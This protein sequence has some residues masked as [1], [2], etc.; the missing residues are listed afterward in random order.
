LRFKKEESEFS[1][2][3]SIFKKLNGVIWEVSLVLEKGSRFSWEKLNLREAII[4]YRD[5]RYPPENKTVG[6][7]FKNVLAEQFPKKGLKNLPNYIFFKNPKSEIGAGFLIEQVG[8][9]GKSLGGAKIALHQANCLINFKDAKA[10]D[11]I[12]LAKMVQKKVFQKFGVFLEP[13]IQL[14]G[15]D[16]YSLV[17]K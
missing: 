6:S 3:H 17:K 10:K 2:K 8:L 11:V 9:A 13:E 16:R 14:I 15:F 1:Y 12:N 5:V 7:F 4:A